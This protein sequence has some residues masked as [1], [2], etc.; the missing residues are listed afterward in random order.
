M[1]QFCLNQRGLVVGWNW[2]GGCR[3]VERASVVELQED[4]CKGVF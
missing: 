4:F 2:V 3:V 1:Y